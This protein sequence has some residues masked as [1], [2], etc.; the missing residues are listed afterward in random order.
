[1]RPRL[2]CPRLCPNRLRPHPNRL[3]PNRPRSNHFHRARLQTFFELTSAKQNSQ[4]V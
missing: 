1:L 3:H 2:N 4:E